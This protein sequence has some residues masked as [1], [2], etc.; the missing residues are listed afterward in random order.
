[1]DYVCL[2]NNAHLEV[3][4][5]KGVIKNLEELYVTITD[6]E[7]R[8]IEIK[9]EFFDKFFTETGFHKFKEDALKVNKYITFEYDDKYK[10]TYNNSAKEISQ[11]KTFDELMHYMLNRKDK[12]LPVMQHLANYYTES[13]QE[14]LSADS[15]LSTVH[16]ELIE[17]ENQLKTQKDKYERLLDNYKET[18]GRLDN[19]VSRINFQYEK[20]IDINKMNVIEVDTMNFRKI[21]Y[22]KEVTRV[23]YVDTFIE[24]LKEILKTVKELPARLIVIEPPNSYHK[25]KLYKTCKPHIDL[26]YKDVFGSD[27]FM[28]G[29]QQKIIETVLNNPSKVDFLII[30]DRGSNPVPHIKGAGV[31]TLYT[32]SDLDDIEFSIDNTRLITYRTDTLRVPYIEDYNELSPQEA[33]SAYSSMDIT[34]A[35]IKLLE[36]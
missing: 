12:I 26:T 24:N 33:I 15:K 35:V 20:D 28:A 22:I 6:L 7:T 1:M 14:I 32:V 11:L 8:N 36:R 19:L 10:N 13:F 4:K 34:K 27:I 21:L 23:H 5:G 17:S 2:L 9:S 30:L 25:H 18:T 16:L 3:I 31:E 29:F